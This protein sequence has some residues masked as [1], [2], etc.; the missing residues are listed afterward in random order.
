MPLDL[1]I[2][3]FGLC[4]LSF[5]GIAIFFCVPII[6]PLAYCVNLYAIQTAYNLNKIYSPIS[7]C[8]TVKDYVTVARRN[9]TSRGL[10]CF[11]FRLINGS[12]APVLQARDIVQG[13]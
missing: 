5:P 3:V 8:Q 4:E 2:L 10:W 1:S 13:G 7:T 6:S 11:D 9:G 12:D